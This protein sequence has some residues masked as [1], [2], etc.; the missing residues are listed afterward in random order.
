[1]TTAARA[2]LSHLIDYAGLFPPARL[3]LP[4]ALANYRRYRDEAEAWMLGRF[5][6]PASRLAETGD[7]A[8]GWFFPE[9]PW[10]FS[11][12]GR[13]GSDWKGYREGLSADLAAITTFRE[14]FGDAVRLPVYHRRNARCHRL[15]RS[16]DALCRR[17]VPAL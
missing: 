15:R 6:V 8:G 4:T 9:D 2:F 3:D 1:M 17:R 11:V 7:I 5:I 12:L 10:E 14:R 13:G 16:P